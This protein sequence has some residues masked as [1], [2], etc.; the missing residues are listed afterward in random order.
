MT[1]ELFWFG[2]KVD[3]SFIG[4]GVR[5]GVTVPA[6]PTTDVGQARGFSVEGWIF[7]MAVSNT[8]PLVEWN[9]LSNLTVNPGVQLW[10]NNP[11]NFGVC[12]IYANVWD[13]NGVA[14]ELETP[15]LTITNLGWQHVALTF[16]KETG[17]GR[18]Y[19][20]GQVA[21][22]QALAAPGV[23]VPNTTSDLLFGL[24]PGNTNFDNSFLG[25]LDEMGLYARALTPCE[26]EAIFRSGS[27]GKY[28]TNV[29]Y[30]PVVT[31]VTL[32]NPGP[33]TVV[34]TN[35][36][37]WTNGPQWEMVSVPFTTTT[38]NRTPVVIRSLD[39]N[40]TIDDITLY[41]YTTNLASGAMHF[42]ENTNLAVTPIKFAPTPY[43]TTNFPPTM[44]YSNSFEV[45]TQR[46]Y[47]AGQTIAGT[48]SNQVVGA[49]DWLVVTGAVSVI[50]NSSIAITG[51]NFLVLST[52]DIRT[53]LPTVPGHKYVLTYK[54][55][56]PAA[57]GW[58][59]GDIEPYSRRARDLIGG[60]H[61]AFYR[62]ATNLTGFA[63]V[64]AT[65]LAF[66]V[67]SNFVS[68]I[69]LADPHRLR[70]TNS[71]TIEGWIYPT[72]RPGSLGQILFRGDARVCL[73]PYYFAMTSDRRL[74]FHIEAEKTYDCGV[75]LLTPADE[76][77]LNEWQHV[78]AVFE[79][80]V[81]WQ[82]NAPWPTNEM[83]LFIN[84][85]V[86]L[87]IEPFRRAMK[88]KDFDYEPPSMTSEQDR[89]RD[90]ER[91]QRG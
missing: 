45:A 17:E 44:V 21:A 33:V 7:P 74:Q 86:M 87:R 4:N 76:V 37:T 3:R 83:R 26:V 30:C 29:L 11:T 63:A 32:H 46:V 18:L 31:E 91:E 53:E 41:A 14:H 5:S 48:Y 22:F 88:W 58:W 71:F 27:N 20:N 70:L 35:G 50:S 72:N 77:A 66:G 54:V 90:R 15:P 84:G 40:L 85:E 2:G 36:L 62:P 67:E 64:G 51:T 57:V 13:T 79:G 82:Q 24:H 49:R 1:G 65:S 59:N 28:G 25:G 55:R 61:G 81:E 43:R 9:S 56:G 23:L 75:N 89:A 10:L 39:P 47:T 19:V 34:V 6:N 78:A 8:A 73:E 69:E 68:K 16:D 12:S 42:T 52:N 80:N 60:D 38:T